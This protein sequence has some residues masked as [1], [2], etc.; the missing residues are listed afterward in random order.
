MSDD[1][2]LANL[3][4]EATV[5]YLQGM[6]EGMRMGLTTGGLE[7]EADPLY[8][9]V[10]LKAHQMLASLEGMRRRE[11]GEQLTEY[12]DAAVQAIMRE[13]LEMIL[14]EMKASGDPGEP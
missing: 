5:A 9:E 11:A 12:Q 8:Q 14:E 7:P 6:A 1:E 4:A 3:D 13:G 10:A 2:Y